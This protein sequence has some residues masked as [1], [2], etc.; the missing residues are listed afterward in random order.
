M[1]SLENSEKLTKN[2]RYYLEV[3]ETLAKIEPF[4]NLGIDIF[5]VGEKSDIDKKS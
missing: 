4:I 2:L 3:E 1:L 5:I